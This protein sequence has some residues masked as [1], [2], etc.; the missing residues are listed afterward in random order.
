M[1]YALWNDQY[2]LSTISTRM[3]L[4]RGHWNGSGRSTLHQRNESFRRFVKIPDCLL[5]FNDRISFI[6]PLPPLSLS[7]SLCLS[8]FHR[9]T[10]T[11]SINRNP[12]ATCKSIFDPLETRGGGGG[13]K[14]DFQPI[15]R[16]WEI[17]FQSGSQKTVIDP[18]ELVTGIS[19]SPVDEENV[20][21]GNF[22]WGIF[23]R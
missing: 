22:V 15:L 20:P 16:L 2:R 8:L 21:F 1:R 17:D 12:F 7:L 19:G 18:M 13:G 4:R 11:N 10:L 3:Q 23:W 14:R 9:V 6:R 5:A